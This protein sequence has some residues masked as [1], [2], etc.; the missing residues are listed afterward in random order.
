MIILAAKDYYSDYHSQ[1][2]TEI[3]AMSEVSVEQLVKLKYL[4]PVY[5][6]KKKL[7]DVENSLVKVVKEKNNHYA[8]YVALICDNHKSDDI[9]IK[10]NTIPDIIFS[11]TKEGEVGYKTYEEDTTLVKEQKGTTKIIVTMHLKDNDMLDSYYYVVRNDQ[12]NIIKS[13]K[14]VIENKQEEILIYTIEEDGS[15]QIEIQVKDKEGNRKVQ[16]SPTY[17]L[18]N[19]APDC[20]V[21]VENRSNLSTNIDFTFNKG[22]QNT[23]STTWQVKKE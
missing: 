8:Y 13:V 9:T 16:V 4:D 7:C 14:G 12:N 21:T 15:Y 1:L 22:K 17:I 11:D 18:D 3:G 2:P 23:K 6:H 19:K 20:S 5:D 10:D